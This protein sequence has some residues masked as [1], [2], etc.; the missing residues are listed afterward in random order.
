MSRTTHLRIGV[1]L[2]LGIW[3]FSSGAAWTDG[4][5]PVFSPP[6]G[7]YYPSV[8]YDGD[9]FSGHGAAFPYKMWYAEGSAS[10]VGLAG[11]DDG[12]SWTVL[13]GAVGGLK[14]G[15]YHVQVLYDAG[16]FGGTGYSYRVWYWDQYTVYD[17]S[18]IRTARSADGVTWTDDQPITQV[19]TSVINTS[20][21]NRGSYGP[22]ALRFKPT[23][24]A[25]LDDGDILNNRYV[26]YYDGTTGGQEAWGLAYSVDGLLWKGYNSGAAPVLPVGGAGAW[27]ENYAAHGSVVRYPGGPL[28]LWYGGGISA[29]S[30][31]IGH[32]TSP[33]GIVWT[34]DPANPLVALGCASPP[35]GLGCSGTWNS[36]RNYTPVVLA[37]PPGSACTA[38]AL[39]MWRSG[40]PTGGGDSTKTIGFASLS[41]T[42]RTVPADYP[43]IQA[44]I[45]ACDPGDT[46]QVAAGTYKENLVIRKPLDLAGAGEGVT[47]LQPAISDPDCGGADGTDPLCAGA[48]HIILVQAD[49]VAIHDLTLDG[50]NPDLTSG[51]IRNGADIDARNG[52]I[53]N[54]PLGPFDHLTVHH[55]T[56]RDIYLRGIYAY[57]P[58]RG[59]IDFHHNTVDN[60]QGHSYYSIGIFSRY[61]TGNVS[62]NTV[63]RCPDAIS[64]NWSHGLQFLRNTVTGSGSGVHTDNAGSSAG[65]PSDLLEDNQVSAGVSFGGHPTYGVWA[66]NPYIPVTVRGNTVSGADVGLAAHRQAAPTGVVAFSENS[67]D[68]LSRAG[69]RGALVSTEGLGWGSGNASATFDGDTLQRCATGLQV[70]Q[71]AGFAAVAQASDATITNHTTGVLVNG[72]SATVE[73][74]DLSANFSYGVNNAGGSATA[75]CNWWGSFTGPSHV[76][77]P[78]GTGSAA[79]DGVAYDP[80]N[81]TNRTGICNGCVLKPA[82]PSIAPTGPFTFC[83]GDAVSVLLT[84]SATAGT[85]QWYKDGVPIPGATAQNY[86]ATGAGSFTVKVTEAGCAS[87]PSGAVQIAVI[88]STPS[89][90]YVDD[91]YAALPAGTAVDWPYTGSGSHLIG[92]D[93][94]ATVQGGV[95]AVAAGGTVNV[96]NGSYT[97]NVVIG[98]PLTLAGQSR[99]GVVVMPALSAPNPCTGSSLC[100]GAASTV[101]LVQ[102]DH[103]T[104]HQLTVDGDN[105]ALVSGIVRNGADLDARNGIITN[106]LAGAFTAFEVHDATVRNI[107]LRGVYASTEGTFNFHH[108]AVDNI[109]GD[110]YSIGIF[111]WYGP[112]IMDS[113]TVSRCNDAISANHSRGIQF[114]N[115]IVTQSGSGVHTDNAGDGGGTPDIIRGNSVSDG[116]VHSYGIWTFVPYL[117]PTVEENTIT[118]CE[119]GLSAWG[120]G[121]PVTHLFRRNTVTGP[122]GASGSVGAYIT[123][124]WISW[125]YSDISV[126]FRNNAISGFETGVVLTADEQP[127]NPG[128]WESHSIE[129]VFFDNSLVGNLTLGT[130]GT[131]A[132][133]ASANWWGTNLPDEVKALANGGLLVD[134]TP[135]FHGGVDI[136]AD[137]GF[138][139]DFSYLHVDDDSPQTGA[140]GRAQ[141][142]IDLVLDGAPPSSST[143]EVEAGTYT[144]PLN[145]ESRESILLQGSGRDTTVFHPASTLP[146]NVGGYGSSRTAALRVV[147][148]MD[149]D[150]SG[151]TF[152]YA[153]VSGNNVIGILYWNASG[154][155]SANRY[156]NMG[157]P[158]ASGYYGEVTSYWRAPD[159]PWSDGNRAPIGINGCEFIDTGRI[160][161]VTHD[162][163]HST[164]TG[165][166]FAKT[167]DDFGYAMEIGSTST[168]LV[169]DNA[170][171][172]YDTPAAMDH[173][174]SGALYIEN[175]FTDAVTSPIAKPVQVV[176]NHITGCQWG[177]YIGNE[178]DGYAGDVDIQVTLD[179]NTVENA[180]IAPLPFPED[181]YGGIYVTDED[182]AQ[183]SSVTVTG[184]GNT[185]RNNGPTGIIIAAGGDADIIVTLAGET[186][187][188][189]ARGVH[190]SD[191][192]SGSAFSLSVTN[193]DLS[194]NTLF[195]VENTIAG[196]VF[197]AQCDWWGT[198]TGPTHSGNP[199]G[200]GSASSGGVDYTPWT[201]TNTFDCAVKYAV[202]TRLVFTQQPTDAVVDTAIAPAVALRAE[203]DAGNL[204]YNFHGTL[205][206]VAATIGDN[207][208]GG[209]LS[210]TAAQEA[211][212]GTVA[213]DDLAIDA[214]GV[215]YSLTGTAGAPWSFAPESAP[216]DILLPMGEVIRLFMDRNGGDPSIA[217]LRFN[218]VGDAN[219]NVYVSTSPVTHPFDVSSSG[220]K[221]CAVPGVTPPSGGYRQKLGSD[222]GLAGDVLYFL[223]TA[224]FGKANSE[225]P[226]GVDSGGTPRSAT[227]HCRLP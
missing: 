24:S 197:D 6:G 34:R 130:Q 140:K 149:I 27:D 62:D 125:G 182:R 171:S 98:T 115:N 164:I 159:P 158:D 43:T 150:V 85:W 122:S 134:Y 88:S 1:L 55:T 129:A 137:P 10:A 198:P 227:A 170:I 101:L 118:N 163:I 153:T 36:G 177:M 141:E 82:T 107:Y 194:G 188:G 66:F 212:H 102:A 155:H 176:G 56:V 74:S 23:G 7:A 114:L 108:N 152:D 222:P 30:E 195:G 59:T 181:P 154:N 216:F 214:A 217:D 91:G 160:G 132:C 15:G 90:T 219:Y 136:G 94:F 165:N 113:N 22:I 151:A 183:G 57:N 196:V 28:E 31:G 93:A 84:A 87:L 215:G 76:G 201:G 100:G 180:A 127:W 109:Q 17:I 78:G 190:A 20:G 67:V 200:A 39:K 58:S 193:S 71:Q 4:T 161:L 199:G 50:D 192:G 142:G 41:P 112:G 38:P 185:I 75:T 53:L 3:S 119:T 21:W 61:A 33:D 12:L 162:W 99:T 179:G 221:D 45:D 156:R 81:D 13:S 117:A 121:A 144:E 104:I 80:W 202:P 46:V 19:G 14:A 106:Y 138:Q 29:S 124:D 32:A 25:T 213:F 146:W 5:N 95:N 16:G 208:A 203:D 42:V 128:P 116:T 184:G 60:V 54:Q 18:A 123:T 135:W 120:Q 63:S 186:V 9:S 73:L 40:R 206:E 83:A 148:S 169:Q 167:M 47:T 70:D 37:R 11:S 191:A 26:M 226:L 139:G 44:A 207:P 189:H 69:S 97:E 133:D 175:S 220:R 64:A 145:I 205:G 103:V 225:G 143:V 210:G 173:S 8:L 105:P 223:V 92:C 72:G 224:D 211:D 65:D 96:A 77:N 68:G 147:E 51:I 131:Y 209:S 126:D 48:S 166:T 49:C 110:G 204:G 168:A 172:G 86:T 178:F 187:T 2:V 35:S 79:S 218:D 157:R 111:A 174:Q 52:V 89:I